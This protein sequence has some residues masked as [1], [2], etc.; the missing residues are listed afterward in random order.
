[1]R[2]KSN[3]LSKEYIASFFRV[4]S[5]DTQVTSM[6][7]EKRSAGKKFGVLFALFEAVRCSSET[8]VHFRKTARC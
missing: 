3:E 6:I 1:M 4:E 7:Q 8:S 2:Q 5:F